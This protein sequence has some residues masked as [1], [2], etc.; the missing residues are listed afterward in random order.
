MI[1][2]VWY[3]T[4]LAGRRADC[5]VLDQFIAAVRGGASRALVVHGEA[6][7]GKTALLD[8]VADYAEG[9]RLIRAVGVQTEM[10][11]AFATLHQLCVP[12]L[13]Y[14]ERLPGL[15]HEALRT[16][17]GLSVGPPPDR[18]L[19]GLAVLSLLAEAAEHKPLLCLVDDLQWADRASAQALTFAARRLGTE[20]VGLVLATRALSD[21]LAGLPELAVAGLREADARALLEAVLTVPIDTQVR[22]QIV[23]EAHGNPLALLELPRALTAA[24]LAGGFGL[25][26]V[27]HLPGNVEESFQRRVCALPAETRRLL[28]LAAADPAGDAALV[29][30]GQPGGSASAPR[31]RSP[32]PRLAWSSSGSGYGSVTRWCGRWPTGRCQPRRDG[33]RTRHWQRPPTRG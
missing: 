6:G 26:G 3:V 4:E 30:Q 11:L 24:E 33:R 13:D 32:Q 29:W 19:T 25:P 17:F 16:V 12:L 1:L 5:D 8:Y 9:C 21:D 27:L 2:I 23:A 31:Q 28:V 15:Q 20:S 10:E 7:V 22:D 14:L 18:F